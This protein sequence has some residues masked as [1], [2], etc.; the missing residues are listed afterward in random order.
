MRIPQYFFVHGQYLLHH[1]HGNGVAVVIDG[2]KASFAV[3]SI[4]LLV[5]EFGLESV[6]Q[7]TNS[8]IVNRS[9]DSA[10]AYYFVRYLLHQ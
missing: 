1:L 5:G 4:A 6:R 7:V 8:V 10:S 2:E 9:N 3:V